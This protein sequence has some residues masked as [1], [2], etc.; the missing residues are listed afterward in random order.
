[1]GNNCA[2]AREKY[3]SSKTKGLE[4][5][6]NTKQRASVKY[7]QARL[8]YDVYK[9]KARDKYEETKMKMQGYSVQPINDTSDTGVIT[10]FEQELPLAKISLDDYERRIKKFVDAEHR[11]ELSLKQLIESFKDHSVL[12][13]IENAES[14]T[15]KILANPAMTNKNGSYF[16]PYLMLV[17][18]L[19]CASNPK[20]KAQKF[21]E[22]C[23]MDLLPTLSAGDKELKEYFP[24]LCEISYEMMIAV[25]NDCNP[26]DA[27][28]EL[29]QTDDYSD[30]YEQLF[31]EDETGY[32][33]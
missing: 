31:D 7:Q 12:G 16:I 17:G 4:L 18:I 21:F 24:K 5:Y 23:Q 20:V 33:D 1:M 6:N 11:E 10:K 25:Y 13:E 28:P 22:L 9:E 32:L 14:V 26:Q 27:H 29:L 30:I 19:Y 2:G 3:D 15:R 8:S